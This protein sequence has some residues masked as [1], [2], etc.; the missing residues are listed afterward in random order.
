MFPTLSQ[1]VCDE[2]WQAWKAERM[3]R[4]DID[5]PPI[6]EAPRRSETTHNSV[7]EMSCLSAADSQPSRRR[8]LDGLVYCANPKQV[9]HLQGTTRETQKAAHNA[10]CRN[11]SKGSHL[12][13]LANDIPSLLSWQAQQIWESDGKFGQLEIH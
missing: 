11:E 1:S 4:E 7:S 9:K 10:R 2:G 8:K 12:D 6:V 5:A 3:Q 13:N